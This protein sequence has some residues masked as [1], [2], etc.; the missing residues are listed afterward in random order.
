MRSLRQE[1]HLTL[2]ELSLRSGV[3]RRTITL[4]EAG[5]ANASL[6]TLD[7]LAQALGTGFGSL[8]LP[9]PP[10]PLVP[11]GPAQVAPIWEDS[12]G[13][14]ARLLSSYPGAGQIE[15]WSWDLAGGARYQAEADPRGTEELVL[16]ATGRLVLEV[17]GERF[18][19]S[20][21]AH[22]R[23]PTDGGYSY[24]NPGPSPASFITVVLQP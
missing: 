7:K 13:S 15:I 24:S 18:A 6:G 8:V 1:R 14:S 21:G 16:V 5:Q 12:R 23:A 11:A 20:S 4:L 19:L 17:A 9:R 3:S 22:V 10:A 2:D